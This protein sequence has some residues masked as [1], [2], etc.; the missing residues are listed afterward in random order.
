MNKDG[1]KFIKTNNIIKLEKR[2]KLIDRKLTNIRDNHIH[3]ATNKIVK[4][5]PYR[6][7]IEDLNIQGMMK[8]KYLSKAIQEQKLYEFR[9]QLTY[10]TEFMGIELVIADRWFPSSKTCSSCD[11]IK[12]DLKLSDRTFKCECGLVI[13][14]DKN[15][16]INLS[17]Y[18]VS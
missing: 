11:T 9:R 14:R 12:K 13:D 6:V 18:K 1:E 15:A 3:Q 10:K 16:S 8:N 17:N 7:V 4:M 5:L 2:L